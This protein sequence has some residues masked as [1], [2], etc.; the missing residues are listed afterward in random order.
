MDAEQLSRIVATALHE[1]LGPGDVTGGHL[2]DTRATGR[3]VCE[4][5]GMVVCGLAVAREAFLQV[6]PNTS[7][8]IPVSDGEEAASGQLLISCSGTG[9]AL[10]AAERVALNFLQR[11]CGIATLTRAYVNAVEGT[12]T[13]IADTRKTTPGLRML[14]K[15]A[16]QTGGGHN[17]RMGLYDQVLVK[18]NHI[19][20][21]GSIAAAVGMA[22]GLAG[23]TMKVEVEA[24]NMDEV[25]QALAA[26]A[27]IIML[28]N[29]AVEDMRDA[30]SIID[31]KAVVEASG[32]VT[33][34]NVRAI[35]ETRVDLISV[36]RLTHSAPS[37][38][39]S[40][41]IFPA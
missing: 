6:D 8:E 23:A 38:E 30:V 17:H 34:E 10:L 20:L 5:D 14:E 24:R 26:E 33:L 9:A 21:T 4:Q 32:G 40:M 39:I 1:D 7:V 31:R 35:A 13:M 18:D 16:V 22:R 3:I 28:D 15:Y 36:G 27:D 41:D 25:E 12:G 19:A 37:A 29:F 2:L 11:M